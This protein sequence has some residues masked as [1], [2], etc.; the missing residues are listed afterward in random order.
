MPPPIHSR[1]AVGVP[2]RRLK[3]LAKF[4]LAEYF[5]ISLLSALLRTN[6]LNISVRHPS[7][8]IAR[9]IS[10]RC[11]PF[12]ERRATPSARLTSHVVSSLAPRFFAMKPQKF[13]MASAEEDRAVFHITDRSPR[14][15]RASSVQHHSTPTMA[16]DPHFEEAKQFL[17]REEEEGNSLYDHLSRVLLKVI[18]DKVRTVLRGPS[19]CGRC[20]RAR[21]NATTKLDRAVLAHSHCGRVW[22]DDENACPTVLRVAHETP[23]CSV[24]RGG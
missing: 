24:R 7:W 10:P 21:G 2:I 8:C 1:S 14:V 23:S 11:G 19:R 9:Q 16:R 18:I 22:L 12:A 15:G 4:A 5:C 17:R 13:L 6:Q 20:A 3:I